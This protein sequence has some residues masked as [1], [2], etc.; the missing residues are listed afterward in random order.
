MSALAETLTGDITDRDVLGLW[1]RA[2]IKA[3]AENPS[4]EDHETRVYWFQAPE[5]YADLRV[6][7]EFA[8]GFGGA[9]LKD[10]DTDTL[11]RLGKCEGF[12]GISTVEDS[13]C[14]WRRFINLQG[15]EEGKDIGRLCHAPDGMYE[16]GVEADFVELWQNDPSRSSGMRAEI[17]S[18]G[19][20]RIAI[21]VHSATHFLFACDRPERTRRLTPFQ[22]ELADALICPNP[23]MDLLNSL[24]EAE[25]SFGHLHSGAAVIDLSTLPTRVGDCLFEDVPVNGDPFRTNHRSFDGLPYN[26]QWYKVARD[27]LPELL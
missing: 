21:L 16:Y 14:T 7:A 19:D 27:R 18:D 20:G 6:P 13:V 26:R 17:Y 24:F 22:V 9:A 3:P 1:R 4:H 25:Y 12:A 2:Y 11:F 23:Q 5:L 8:S 10:L 15:P